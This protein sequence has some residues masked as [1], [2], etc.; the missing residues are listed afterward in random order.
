[1]ASLLQDPLKMQTACRRP[2]DRRYGQETSQTGKPQMASRR[3]L[4]CSHGPERAIYVVLCSRSKGRENASEIAGG[5]S[6]GVKRSCRPGLGAGF[7]HSPEA[8]EIVDEGRIGSGRVLRAMK[9]TGRAISDPALLSIMGTKR[10]GLLAGGPPVMKPDPGLADQVG[11]SQEQ[12][13]P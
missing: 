13:R 8:T 5:R 7:S 2:L 3:F 12:G 11:Q 1:M 6:G 4:I 10:K 9:I